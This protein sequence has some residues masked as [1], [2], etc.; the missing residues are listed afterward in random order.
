MA[1]LTLIGKQVG[2]RTGNTE[3]TAI[4]GHQF[5]NLVKNQVGILDRTCHVESNLRREGFANLGLRE[6]SHH[7]GSI[8]MT[9]S[10]L[11]Q[12]DKNAL[13]AAAEIHTLREEHRRIEMG[14]EG[15]HTAVQVTGFPI[16]G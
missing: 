3:I 10:H 2:R 12:V 6:I 11:V 8:L 4:L 7:D 16:V 5:L 15:E 9:F 14:I 13:V 1:P